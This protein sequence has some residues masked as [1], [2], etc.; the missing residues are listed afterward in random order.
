MGLE[1]EEEVQVKG[2]ENIFNKIIENLPIL[3]KR[4]SSGTGGFKNTKQKRNCLHHIM[5]KTLS[6]QNKE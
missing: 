1:E 3:R 4:G 2:I 6:I 5:V